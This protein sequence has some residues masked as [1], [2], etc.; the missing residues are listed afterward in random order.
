LA[1][2]IWDEFEGEQKTETGYGI[3]PTLTD[4][5]HPILV[6]DV[7][8]QMVRTEGDGR[9]YRADNAPIQEWTFEAYCALPNPQQAV[10]PTQAE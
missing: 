9:G 6:V 10:D 4:N 1:R 3:S 8:A 7:A 5:E 2:I